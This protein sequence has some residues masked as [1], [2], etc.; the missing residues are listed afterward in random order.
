M[1]READI[2]LLAHILHDWNDGQAVQILKRC[3]QAMRP[4]GRVIVI[5]MLLG[6]IGEPGL[7]PLV[8]QSVSMSV[9]PGR[10]YLQFG[11]IGHGA[12]S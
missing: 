2:Y 9:R 5:E 11:E 3:R 6:E 12:P 1:S 7:A 10:I 4:G 8:G